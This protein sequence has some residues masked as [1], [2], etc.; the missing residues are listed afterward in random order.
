[1]KKSI[2]INFTALST[3]FFF[4]L[5]PQVSIVLG[6]EA[7]EAAEPYLI[8]QR[9]IASGFMGDTSNIRLWESWR[10]TPYDSTDL[11]SFCVKIAYTPG[12]V[13]WAGIYWQNRANNWGRFPGENFSEYGYQKIIFWARGETGRE[14]VEFKAG[15]INN[16]NLPYRDSFRATIGRIRLSRKWQRYEIDLRNLNLSSVIGGFCWVASGSANPRGVT[17]Y[18]DDIKYVVR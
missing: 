13:G 5:I 7:R 6:Q 17:F 14:L 15:D 10:D 9:F 18:L 4:I 11:D 2:K 12:Q 3:L 1:M 16:P 8:L